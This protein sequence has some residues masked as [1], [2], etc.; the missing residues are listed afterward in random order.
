MHFIIYCY[1][2]IIKKYVNIKKIVDELIYVLLLFLP[3]PILFHEP[4]GGI[5]TIVTR[6]S[7][8]VC[9]QVNRCLHTYT[10]KSSKKYTY[11]TNIHLLRI[12]Y[13]KIP[14]GLSAIVSSIWMLSTNLNINFVENFKINKC[15]FFVFFLIWGLKRL[16]SSLHLSNV[17]FCEPQ[18]VISLSISTLEKW[19]K[20]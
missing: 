12:F 11:N 5:E 2:A 18:T 9:M 1:Y 19:K 20:N 17:I 13:R 10:H 7:E 14:D 8:Q 6:V 4:S 15:H 3:F 16:F